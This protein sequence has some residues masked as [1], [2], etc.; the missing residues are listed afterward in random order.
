MSAVSGAI[1]ITGAASGIGRAVAEN[2]LAS[3]GAVIAVDRNEADLEQFAAAMAQPATLHVCSG[4]VTRPADLEKAIALG[5]SEFGSVQ[6]V[7]SAAGVWTPGGA[8]DLTDAQWLRG[9]EINL[10]GV[11]NT[12]RA[13]I[14]QFLLQGSGS[15]VAIASDAGLQG[16]QNCAAYVAAK[17]G[18]VGL[19]RAMALDYGPRGIRSNAVC[20]GFVETSMFQQIFANARPGLLESRRAEVPMGRF[21][22]PHEIAGVVR[23]LLGDAGSFINGAAL[24][25][26]GGSTAGYFTPTQ[27]HER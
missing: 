24:V 8:A 2:M 25:I 5:A 17:H 12:A 11:F 3:G 9:I 23:M 14:G 27:S 1:V 22:Q 7:V 26:D 13:A 21:A 15:F 19:V 6:G 20:P 16:S 18:V 10:T 4:D